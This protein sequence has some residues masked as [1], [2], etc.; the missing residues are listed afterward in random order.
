MQSF[1]GIDGAIDWYGIKDHR[2]YAA[3]H[4]N[5]NHLITY[6]KKAGLSFAICYE[7]QT[8]KHLVNDR[9]LREA[10]LLATARK[11][12]TGCRTTG[13]SP[14]NTPRSPVG[15]CSSYSG[16]STS[17]GIVVEGAVFGLAATSVLLHSEH[18]AGRSRWGIR[19]ASST[20][21]P[22]RVSCRLAR[23]PKPALRE[24][25]R[26]HGISQVPRHLRGSQCARKLRVP[27]TTKR[28]QFSARR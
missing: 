27:R 1:A 22:R 23:L 14:T 10:K 15:P 4:R 11:S 24:G 20:R 13:L 25:R 16:R 17:K 7:D 6:I 18:T 12:Y 3:I 5:T 2:D 28:E 9:V 8:I 26:R 21:R 19:V